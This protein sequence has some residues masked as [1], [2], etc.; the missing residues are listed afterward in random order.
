[1]TENSDFWFDY[2]RTPRDVTD[3]EGRLLEIGEEPIKVTVFS[4]GLGRKYPW[5]HV[6]MEYEGLVIDFEAGG[7]RNLKADLPRIF[8]EGIRH[9]YVFPAAAG[10]DGG[11]LR[12]AIL[13]RRRQAGD[14]SLISN[15]CAD[16][17]KEVLE[18]AGAR[19]IGEFRPLDISVPER[20]GG[21]C[22]GRGVEIDVRTTNLY[23][24]KRR[25]D[26]I[27]LK[28]MLAYSKRLLAG[29]YAAEEW[30]PDGGSGEQMRDFMVRRAVQ[31]IKHVVRTNRNDFG[32]G[33]VFVDYLREKCGEGSFLE[34]YGI[35]GEMRRTAY[36]RHPEREALYLARR[37]GPG[38]FRGVKND[39]RS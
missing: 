29:E 12:E 1:M 27:R 8:E 9:Y 39:G 6:Q 38:G 3:T 20:I 26:F 37:E 7:M 13:R 10:I 34:Q 31:E 17:V 19:G 5:G 14:Y 4:P 35:A 30:L 2:D 15:N 21:W 33:K 16:Q 24:L 22:A 36:L 11:R 18:E 32:T 25:E 28:R 23:R